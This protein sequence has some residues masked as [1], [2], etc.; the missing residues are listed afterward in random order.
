MRS[1]TFLPRIGW[2]LF[3]GCAVF[4]GVSNLV[5]RDWFSLAG[6]VLFLAAC[7]VFLVHENHASDR[8]EEP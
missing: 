2:I 3:I 4:Y 5:A 7:I 6:T 8:S 1:P